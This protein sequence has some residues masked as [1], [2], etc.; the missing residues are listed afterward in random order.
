MPNES[1]YIGYSVG[2][3]AKKKSGKEKRARGKMKRSKR[4]IKARTVFV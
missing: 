3:K 2:T 1:K 4:I